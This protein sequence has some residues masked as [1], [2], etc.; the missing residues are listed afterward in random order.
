MSTEPKVLTF[1]TREEWLEGRRQFV[2]ASDVAA[3][4]G[5]DKRRTAAHVYAEKRGLVERGP[6]D[7][8]KKRGRMLESA[9]IGWYGEDTGY[10]VEPHENRLEVHPEYSW[11]A[12]SRDA[13]AV[14]PYKDRRNVEA[15]T[16]RSKYGNRGDEEDERFG[17]A[18]TDEVPRTYLVQTQIQMAVAGIDITDMPVLMAGSE[19]RIYTIPLSPAFI[20]RAIDKLEKFVQCIREGIPPDLDF[21]HP[22]TLD[23]VQAL[24][25]DVEARTIEIPAE[26][27]EH[28]RRLEAVRAF[29]NAAIKAEDRLKAELLAAAGDAEFAKVAGTE[30][31]IHRHAITKNFKPKPAETRVEIHLK[32][33]GITDGEN[34]SN[35][36]AATVSTAADIAGRRG[37]SEARALPGGEGD[38][39]DLLLAGQSEARD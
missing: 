17:E 36:A 10:E 15:K 11:L 25:K 8:S 7:S 5:F 27:E 6:D 9:V 32:L 30:L 21:S 16:A 38:Q 35:F 13:T 29:K 12:A 1:A 37:S 39:S 31:L 18:G 22:K 4:L 19:F 23:L 34:I 28:V 3:I 20:E 24:H 26:Y 2:T 33:K 14:T